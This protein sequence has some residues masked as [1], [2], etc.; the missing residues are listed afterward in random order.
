VKPTPLIGAAAVLGWLVY[1]RRRMGWIERAV[2][3]VVVAAL[4]LYGTGVVHPPSLEHILLS[5]GSA[6]G[7]WTY[8]LVGLLAFLETGAFIGLVAPGE[9]AILLGGFVAGQGK[10]SVVV[11][12]AI[13]WTAAVAGDVTSYFLGR[14]LGREFLL[15]HGERVKITPARLEKVES[16][17]QRWGGSAIFL[18]R[19]VGLIRAVAPFIAGAS[20]LPLRRFLPY[21]IA[22]AG[23]WGCG[24]VILGYVFW[25]SFDKLIAAAKHG[26]LALGALIVIAVGI[27]AAYRWLHEP[28]HRAELRA[29]LVAQ[30]E[31]PALAPI[32]AAARPAV[33]T[34][35]RL[36]PGRCGLEVAT[37]LTVGL[38]GAFVFGGLIGAVEDGPLAVDSR[39]MTVAADVRG[40]LLA[41]LAKAASALGATPAIE[42]MVLVVAAVLAR[43]GRWPE[44]AALVGGMVLVL[45]VSNVTKAVV[46]RP[47]PP[48]S[49]V[50]TT[51]SA[52]PSG[53]AANSV[54]WLAAS[55]ALARAGLRLRFG[56]PLAA[57][58]LLLAAAIGLSRV[59]LRAH[60]WTD[61]LG[62]WGL[63]L[64]CFCLTALI[65]VIVTSVRQNAEQPA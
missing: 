10:I 6:L 40:T 64:A 3:L 46:E 43:R 31:R 14:R 41:D 19:F 65:A 18:G 36:V 44:A 61:V 62:G 63:G 38:I 47:R 60:W 16:F 2:W 34:V 55:V 53:H 42:L 52:Y 54:A 15:R 9:T 8:L 13:V 39:A 1:R 29:W 25:H 56:V 45:I 28:G 35:V 30:G 4:V 17:F 58:G 24:L 49:L 21:D 33:R 50:S 37:L 22:G 27:V 23:I 51:G 57:V 7:T 48:G 11:L 59:E 12:S 20:R 26:A 5:V 32:V